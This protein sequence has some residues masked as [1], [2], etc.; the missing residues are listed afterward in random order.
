MFVTSPSAQLTMNFPST[1]RVLLC[2]PI[3][4][5]GSWIVNL[6]PLYQPVSNVVCELAGDVPQP[7][8]ELGKR[9][10]IHCILNAFA[11]AE[12][13][14]VNS[15]GVSWLGTAKS[16]QHAQQSSGCACCCSALLGEK[17]K[18]SSVKSYHLNP[19]A[20]GSALESFCCCNGCV[21]G[22]DSDCICKKHAF[23]LLSA[24]ITLKIASVCD[25]QCIDSL[26]LVC[27]PTQ[28]FI[29]RFSMSHQKPFKFVLSLWQGA[30]SHSTLLGY[31]LD[32]RCLPQGLQLG[33]L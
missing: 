11:D 29:S 17:G 18:F 20:P 24:V 7:G 8:L 30:S 10:Q 27:F 14:E 3:L 26:L 33:F 21:S 1:A 32:K 19:P 25:R 4:N 22:R 5:T 23:F 13:M 31:I 15:S 2:K 16:L 6:Y 12:S 28:F 9:W